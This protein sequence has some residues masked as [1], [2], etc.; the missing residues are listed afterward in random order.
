ME[1]EMR[2]PSRQFAAGANDERSAFI[3]FGS[4]VLLAGISFPASAQED[5]KV[6]IETHFSPNRGGARPI[7]DAWVRELTNAT[8]SIRVVMYTFT[9]QP[10]KNALIDAKSRGVD[11]RVLADKDSLFYSGAPS[12]PAVDLYNAGIPIKGYLPLD[13]RDLLH[14]KF[15]LI[16]DYILVTGSANFTAAAV[17][18]NH[19]NS[20]I[21]KAVG[22]TPRF[23][24]S[25]RGQFES[26]WN[27][28][29]ADFNG[30]FQ[31]WVPEGSCL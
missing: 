6:T 24:T 28:E 14:D 22:D 12:C 2:S 18:F 31:D 29:F 10:F 20:I 30:S 21:I 4:F 9:L 8:S 25:Y 15:M 16:D 13:P 7:Q 23:I 5:V 1:S 27:D 19:E 17:Q 11:V 26:M 3:F